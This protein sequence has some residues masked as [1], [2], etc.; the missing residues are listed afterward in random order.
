MKLR[1]DSRLDIFPEFNCVIRGEIKMSILE[2]CKAVKYLKNTRKLHNGT[3]TY[4][5]FYRDLLK[6]DLMNEV[7]RKI[8]G[9]IRRYFCIRV[10]ATELLVEKFNIKRYKRNNYVIRLG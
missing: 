9:E 3:N 5:S 1:N 4:L 8:N 10:P 6:K 2:F 7:K